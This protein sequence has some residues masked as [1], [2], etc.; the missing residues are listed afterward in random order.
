MESEKGQKEFSVYL[1]DNVP[2]SEKMEAAKEALVKLASG[3]MDYTGWLGLP[4]DRDIAEE[5]R[6]RDAAKR[7]KAI[8]QIL[9]VIGIG[10]SYLGAKAVIQALNPNALIYPVRG[11]KIASDDTKIFFAGCNLSAQY[12]ENILNLIKNYETS[13]CVISKSGTTTEPA[14][15]F[16]VFKQALIEKYGETEA[17]TRIYAITSEKKGVLAK[18]AAQEGYVS[19]AIPE[20]VGGRYSVLSPVGLLPMA[21]ADIDTGT[22]LDAAEE[23]R[24]RYFG[25]NS[26]EGAKDVLSY[27]LARHCMATQRKK[28]GWPKTVEVFEYYEPRLAA[29]AEWLKQLFGESEGKKKKGIFPASLS[30]SA[31]LH[32]M[33][34]FLQEGRQIFF[35]TLLDV[36]DNGYDLII[37][38]TAE[39]ALAGRSMNEIERAAT[40]GVIRAHEAAGIPVIRMSIPDFSERSLGQMIYFFEVSCA[41]SAIL[42]GVNPFNQPGVEAYKAEMKA[43]LSKDNR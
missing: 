7:I 25:E 14:A 5:K 8:S 16:A 34:Q 35:E 19:F 39:T 3:Q 37:P 36:K 2:I 23:F 10:G 21:V 41:V 38:D 4:A 40:E 27:A 18:E 15:A 11:C 33:G 20:D 9:I 17:R 30:L 24:Q 26:E 43:E 6:I 22:L 32:S 13:I 29:F 28:G 31:D 12:H 42:T 1:G